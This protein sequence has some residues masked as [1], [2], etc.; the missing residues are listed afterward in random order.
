[1][2]TPG[3]DTLGATV[4][5]SACW[6]VNGPPQAAIIHRR[7][8]ANGDGQLALLALRPS[9]PPRPG[10]GGAPH[11]VWTVSL[12]NAADRP[13]AFEAWVERDDPPFAEHGPRRQS[14][15]VDNGEGWISGQNT[16]NSVATGESPIVV[17]GYRLVDDGV[18]AYSA[19]GAPRDLGKKPTLV[20]P[21]DDGIAL[22]G[23]RAAGNRSG[24]SSRMDGTSVAAPI[25]T[26]L[27]ANALAATGP[28]GRVY[29]AA[30]IKQALRAQATP[31][32]PP[33][34]PEHASVKADQAL[35]VGSG[36][37]RRRSRGL[38]QARAWHRL[39][40]RDAKPRFRSP[41]DDVH[42]L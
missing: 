41:G 2:T 37:I 35:R 30:E 34:D 12:S 23:L 28:A 36:W 24:S 11:G 4:D 9:R 32:D 15:F 5:A 20:A 6:P 31:A 3:G 8:V 25:V 33:P 17:G 14:H 39:R 21:S 42:N 1:M 13:V 7:E 19:A 40:C 26:R 22:P 18:A 16:L 10:D 38:S 29:S 27:I